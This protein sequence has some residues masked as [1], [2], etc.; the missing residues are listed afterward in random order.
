METEKDFFGEYQVLIEAQKDL[1]LYTY[2]RQ[3]TRNSYLCIIKLKTI[4]RK[5]YRI[6]FSIIRVLKKL[7]LNIT[8]K[9]Q[10]LVC[11]PMKPVIASRNTKV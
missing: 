5:D 7:C 11:I 10:G 4:Y 2:R 3:I 8:T 6:D 1:Y 9:F